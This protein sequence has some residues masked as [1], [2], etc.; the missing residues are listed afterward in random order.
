MPE[1][2]PYTP[3]PIQM[4]LNGIWALIARFDQIDY[5][6]QEVEIRL[7]LKDPLP[8]PELSESDDAIF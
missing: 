1:R 8:Q 3:L 4:L 5:R 7:G 2:N 6:L